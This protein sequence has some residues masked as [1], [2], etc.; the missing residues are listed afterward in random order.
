VSVNASVVLRSC[1]RIESALEAIGH[2]QRQDC[3]SFEIVVVEQTEHLTS[4]QHQRLA[5]LE[6]DPRIR[7]IRRRPLGGAG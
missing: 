7:I 4:E 6:R 3:A 5:A 2:V 1:N